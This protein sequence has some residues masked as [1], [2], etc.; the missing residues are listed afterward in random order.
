VNGALEAH[1]AAAP[2]ANAG[3]SPVPLHSAAPPV[4]SSALALSREIELLER[5]RARLRGGDSAG[6]LAEL[7]RVRGDVSALRTEADLL[8]IEAL[9]AH[10]ERPRAEALAAELQR[11]DSRWAQNFRLKRLLGGQ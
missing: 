10:G 4:A 1:R 5:V 7:E 11:R 3:S 2:A 8:R 9:I 6:A